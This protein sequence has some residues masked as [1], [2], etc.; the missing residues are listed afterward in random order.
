MKKEACSNP[1]RSILFLCMSHRA[2]RPVNFKKK[3]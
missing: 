1:T 3:D 2:D